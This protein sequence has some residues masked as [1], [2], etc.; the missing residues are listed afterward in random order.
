M[1]PPADDERSFAGGSMPVL[2]SDRPPPYANLDP[3]MASPTGSPSP[4][5]SPTQR[6]LPTVSPAQAARSAITVGWASLVLSAGPTLAAALDPRDRPFQVVASVGLWLAW[7]AAFA[8]S[9]VPRTV[10]LTAVRIV[11]PAAVPVLAWAVAVTR[12]GG[13]RIDGLIGLGTAVAVTVLVLSAVVGDAFVNGSSYGD[14]RRLP[15]R[16]PATLL[17]GPVPLAWAACLAGASTGPLLL[18]AGRWVAGIPATAVGFAVVALAVRALHGLAR[19]WLVLVPAGVVVHD[20]LTLAEPVLCTRRLIRRIAPAPAGS[21]ATDLTAGALGLA[22]QI[23]LTEPLPATGTR[24]AATME[25]ASFLVAPSRP[26][27]VLRAAHARR[28]PVP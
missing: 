3:A 1:I 17:A 12:E 13:V 28:L 16:P 4:P 22:L 7:T 21:D 2:N 10:S 23:E 5:S 8:A 24:P 18:A 11:M 25:L 14:E 19:R 20:P 6:R 15:L 26:G 9:L 27:E